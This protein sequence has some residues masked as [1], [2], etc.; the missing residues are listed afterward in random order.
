MQRRGQAI[1]NV[2]LQ[3]TQSVPQRQRGDEW[4]RMSYGRMAGEKEELN[5]LGVRGGKWIFAGS[6]NP[7]H[8]RELIFTECQM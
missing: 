7:E 8:G 2:P 5:K 4:M 3:G 6:S 1:G